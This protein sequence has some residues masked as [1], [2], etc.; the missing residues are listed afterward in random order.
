M[1]FILFSEAKKSEIDEER[2][3]SIISK[4]QKK[5]VVVNVFKTKSPD[6]RFY[7]SK[8]RQTPN[9]MNHYKKM[10]ARTFF[11]PLEQAIHEKDFTDHEVK[12]QPERQLLQVGLIKIYISLLVVRYRV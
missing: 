8:K 10:R 4:A 12:H 11:K 6:R 1:I 9:E 7:R 3:N 5:P 2:L